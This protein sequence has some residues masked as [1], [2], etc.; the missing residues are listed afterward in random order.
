MYKPLIG[1]GLG[2]AIGGAISYLFYS[3]DGEENLTKPWIPASPEEFAIEEKDE[4][5]DLNIS[6][7]H[8][9]QDTE[10]QKQL[11]IIEHENLNISTPEPA[12]PLALAMT[13]PVSTSDQQLRSRLSKAKLEAAAQARRRAAS[14]IDARKLPSESKYW[15][16]RKNSCGDSGHK[17]P[18]TT[19][20]GR[21]ENTSPET[22][23]PEVSGAESYSTPPAACADL[24]PFP[25]MRSDYSSES[26]GTP[27]SEEIAAITSWKKEKARRRRSGVNPL[28]PLPLGFSSCSATPT[29]SPLQTMPLDGCHSTT[30]V[31]RTPVQRT[32]VQ[33]T[34]VQR[35]P[36]QRTPA[37]TP[38]H[39]L[40]CTPPVVS[41][42]EDRP[43]EALPAARPPVQDALAKAGFPVSP[44]ERTSPFPAEGVQA[45]PQAT[46][47]RD[48]SRPSEVVRSKMRRA[49]RRRVSGIDPSAPLP[50]GIFSPQQER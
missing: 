44:A 50:L 11:V 19:H 33:R 25:S 13:P 30:P 31:Q 35:T 49:S 9:E 26:P 16:P 28:A 5:K 34:P 37:R 22:P 29:A 23:M 17:S 27:T 46:P 40:R 4:E 32:P 1:A 45:S 12:S 41:I 3:K 7:Q 15:K 42:P 36:V 2:L 47:T 20:S 48:A 43:E 21:K 24:Q 39:P 6:E 38:Q 8:K 14:I 10:E 18:P